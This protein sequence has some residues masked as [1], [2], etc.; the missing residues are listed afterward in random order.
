MAFQNKYIQ[1]LQLLMRKPHRFGTVVEPKYITKS[2]LPSANNIQNCVPPEKTVQ[3]ILDPQSRNNSTI[4]LQRAIAIAVILILLT[5]TLCLVSGSIW[6]AEE[7]IRS[8]FRFGFFVV[9][10]ILSKT[11]GAI[12]HR[13]PVTELFPSGMCLL[14]AF[15]IAQTT[16]K[17]WKL[18]RRLK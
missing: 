6:M 8:G 15:G 17:Q 4:T 16:I 11:S 18:M 5:T 1:R 10:P 13:L 7:P 14:F 9:A 12:Y 2:E 3:I